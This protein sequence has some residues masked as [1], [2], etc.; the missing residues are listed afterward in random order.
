MRTYREQVYGIHTCIHTYMRTNREQV[1]DIHPYIHTYMRTYREH[2]Y[3]IHP[4]IHT[5]IH[6]CAQTGNT[7]GRCTGT[8][9]S[10]GQSQDHLSGKNRHFTSNSSI[11]TTYLSLEYTRT[12]INL[13]IHT[14]KFNSHVAGTS[15]ER[16]CNN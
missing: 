4:S 15:D 9:R 8:N 3:D 6:I 13:L 16:R 11:F 14:N 1:Y 7:R 2:A 10:F 5:Y 12:Y